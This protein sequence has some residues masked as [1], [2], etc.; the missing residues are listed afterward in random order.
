MLSVNTTMTNQFPDAQRCFSSNGSTCENVNPE[1]NMQQANLAQ[2]AQQAMMEWGNTKDPQQRFHMATTIREWVRRDKLLHVPPAN[3]LSCIQRLL[4]IIH[5]GLKPLPGNLP[6]SFY[7]QLFCYLLD[8]L[9]RLTYYRASIPHMLQVIELFSPKDNSPNDFRALICN[10]IQPELLS[11]EHFN[12]CAKEVFHIL[13]N[14]IQYLNSPKHDRLRADFAK[15]LKFPLMVTTLIRTIHSPIPPSMLNSTILVV[16]RFIISKDP[17]LKDQLIWCQ[18]RQRDQIPQ[19]SILLVLKALLTRCHQQLQQMNSHDPEP[20]SRNSEL[21]RIVQVVT[22][23]FDLLNMLMH[24]S[25]AIDAYVKSD[26]ITMICSVLNYQ[27]ADLARSG[28]K[29]LLQVSDSRSLCLTNLKDALPFIMGKLGENL[30]KKAD[31]VVYSGTGFL[32]NVVAH[33]LPVKELAIANGAIPLLFEVL[34][35]YTPL[36]EFPDAPKKKLACG[37]ICNSLRAMNNFLMMWIPMQNGQK[38]EMGPTEKQQVA[39]FLEADVLKRLMTCLSLES[40]DVAPL[41]ELRSTILRFI[42]LLLRTPSISKEGLLDV[43]DDFRRKNLVGHV[44]ISFSWADVQQIT[45]KTKDTKQQFIE[46]VFS[47]LVRL[48]EQFD[49]EQVAHSLYSICCP[50][51]ILRTE[52]SKPQFVLNVLRVCDKI[53]QHCP[54][55]ADGWSIYSSLVEV[56]NNHMNPDIERT[57]N[58]LLRRFPMSDANMDEGIFHNSRF[59]QL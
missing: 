30:T 14:I 16:L 9:L 28:F 19:A 52:Q 54:T 58:S 35:R 21:S 8:V 46:R 25:N 34:L 24:D 6:P 38:M 3:L 18:E 1:V 17:L 45:E 37:I 53:L 36:S 4:A 29:L 22:R 12:H 55:L 23:S 44:A 47:L 31:D 5:D 7:G 57:A 26:G 41:L 49:E 42:F 40:F 51:N 33:K 39:R 11:D 15:S 20:V 13:D 2:V 32:S 48:M 10:A 50:L 27:N 56:F 59:T 43:T